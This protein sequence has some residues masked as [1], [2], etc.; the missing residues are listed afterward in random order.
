M[1]NYSPQPTG[2]A[3]PFLQASLK[4]ITGPSVANFRR[5]AQNPK[6]SLGQGLLWVAI[7][8]A[9]SSLISG[10]LFTIFPNNLY[11]Y[12]AIFEQFGQSENLPMDFFAAGAP[13][14]VSLAT[15]LICGIPVAIVVSVLATLFMAGLYQ[16]VAKLLGGGGDYS[17]LVYMLALVQAPISIITSIISPIPY[18]NC[19]GIFIGIYVIVLQVLAIE[20]VHLFGVGKAVVTLFVPGLV[21]CLLIA[22]L[23]AGLFAILGATLSEVFQQFPDGTIPMP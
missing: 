18:L 19:L 2:E 3:L 9:I 13:T 17:R 5:L 16:L 11:Q 21:L 22:C 1:A 8:A 15:T 4:A 20:S 7:A 6:A 10:V 23:V 12:R 14:I